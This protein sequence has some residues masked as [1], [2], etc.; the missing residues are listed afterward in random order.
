MAPSAHHL[1]LIDLVEMKEHRVT[2]GGMPCFKR[3]PV[4]ADVKAHGD[5]DEWRSSATPDR[6]T[7]ATVDS[8]LELVVLRGRQ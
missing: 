8:A 5:H 4:S 6:Q 7:L 2:G 3:F 1:E